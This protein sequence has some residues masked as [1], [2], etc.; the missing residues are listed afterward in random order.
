MQNDEGRIST[1]MKTLDVESFRVTSGPMSSEANAPYGRFEIPARHANGR[2]LRVIACDGEDP[3]AEGWEHVS[4]S[5]PDSPH[6]CPSWEEM[7]LIKRLFW[8][9]DECVVQFHPPEADYVNNHPGCLHLWRC[10]TGFPQP[11][12][13]LVG[14]PEGFNSAR[15]ALTSD[16]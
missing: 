8:A 10:V 13:H 12:A 14:T 4:V 7:C 2:R 3:A 6:K 1:A 5:L 9:P 11:P 15:A 16:F